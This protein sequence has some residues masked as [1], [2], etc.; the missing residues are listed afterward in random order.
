MWQFCTLN[1][2]TVFLE[3]L[4]R[5]NTELPSDFCM[6]SWGVSK[7][8]HVSN[9]EGENLLNPVLAALFASGKLL[10]SKQYFLQSV[11]IWWTTVIICFSFQ[12]FLDTGFKDK[13]RNVPVSGSQSQTD[14]SAS[15]Y[16]CILLRKHFADN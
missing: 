14:S 1:R 11:H 7:H 3:L 16:I 6:L 8:I 2:Y 10:W 12:G 5:N 15:H 9:S 4:S 13:I